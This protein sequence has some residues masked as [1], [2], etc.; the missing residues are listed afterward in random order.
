MLSVCLNFL[1]MLFT[2]YVTGFAALWLI[3][4]FCT[5]RKRKEGPEAFCSLEKADSPVMAGL[6]VLT[7]YAQTFSLF[8]KVGLLAN[9]LLLFICVLIIII[10]GRNIREELHRQKEKLTTGNI[11]GNIPGN[12]LFAVFLFFLFAY[13][14]SRGIIHYDT[15]LYHAQSIRWVEEYGVVKGLGNLHCR[16]AYNSSS[17]CLSALFSF[18]FLGGQS[19]HCMAG[20]LA[21]LLSG[22]CSEVILA[23]RRKKL[24]LS[25]FAR[26]MAIY[27]LLMVFD[28]MVSP[29]S[30][31]FM[32]LTVFYLVIR[33]LE[34]LE[35]EE[36]SFVPYGLLCLLGVHVM[37]IKLSA[38]LILILVIK[39]A[40]MLLRDKNWRGIIS[41]LLLGA[42]IIMPYLIRN[43]IISGWLVYP[44][45]FPDLFA[46]DWKVPKG[47]ADYDAKEIQVWGRGL[48]DVALYEEPFYTWFPSW[49]AGQG[50]VD[51]L[52]VLTGIGAA[53][54]FF[55]A[56]LVII[57]KGKR[58][59]YDFLPVAAAV[60]SSFLLWLFSA[61]LMRYGCV[62]VYLAATVTFGG[63]IL[64]RLKSRTAWRIIYACIGM[65]ALY[66]LFAFGKE[67]TA[68]GDGRYL[69]CQKDYEDFKVTAYEIDGCTFYYAAEGD[70]TGYQAFP[71]SPARAGIIL[72]GDGL[73]D[74]FASSGTTGE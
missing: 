36:K 4:R 42:V 15:G 60:N 69:V 30:D 54:L 40:A 5:G 66:K 45:T 59:W 25:D 63:F 68:A 67:I 22:V 28:E 33:W 55:P 14:T 70:R 47:I 27:Y 31:Y 65:L 41:F 3:G 20:F 44:F 53:L 50:M 1:Y 56:A 13:G 61:P 24:L 37:G 48:Y 17:F 32:V 9:L 19:L 10:F 35:R 16:L 51:R 46:V 7:V 62:Y 72:R 12:I 43:I 39:P 73:K 6:V 18:A 38:A 57:I 34:L 21:L 71:S 23:V 29:A 49:L 26:I 11:P 2:S 52:F 74:G 64:Y 8:Y 58:E